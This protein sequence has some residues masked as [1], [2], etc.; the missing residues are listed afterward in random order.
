M[1]F[2]GTCQRFGATVS[3]GVS[4][5]VRFLSHP[6]PNLSH[7]IKTAIMA[8]YVTK[9]DVFSHFIFV[10]VCFDNVFI[11]PSTSSRSPR[12]GSS[13]ISYCSLE[14]VKSYYTES[15]AKF[16][17]WHEFTKSQ[18]SCSLLF[19]DFSLE[20]LFRNFQ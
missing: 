14:S 19:K 12:L 1:L 2:G 10:D 4:A 20:I 8:I 9:C 7:D 3:A 5:S 17:V 18:K 6:F 13:D 16:I 15:N 11:L